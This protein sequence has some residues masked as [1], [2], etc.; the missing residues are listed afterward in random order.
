[1]KKTILLTGMIIL[2]S[3]SLLVAGDYEKQRDLH[4]SINQSAFSYKML[5]QLS[6]AVNFWHEANLKGHDR[7]I[8]KYEQEIITIIE[9]DI[10]VAAI[11]VLQANEEK[12]QSKAEAKAVHETKETKLDDRRDY[13]DDVRDAN[14]REKFFKSKKRLLHSIKKSN[15]FSYKFR[16][17]NDYLEFLRREVKAEKIEVAEDTGERYEDR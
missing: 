7:K 9:E 6:Q 5:I 11:Q 3:A 10:R 16:L 14:V 13:T 17:L 8:A 12:R 4:K 15:S 2:L 1:M